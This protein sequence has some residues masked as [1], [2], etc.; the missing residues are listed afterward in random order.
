LA[1][2]IVIS[3]ISWQHFHVILGLKNGKGKR[4]TWAS[5]NSVDNLPRE[6]DL[7]RSSE[8]ETLS[9]RLRTFRSTRS[10]TMYPHPRVVNILDRDLDLALNER[11]QGFL[12]HTPAELSPICAQLE[13]RMRVIG[14]PLKDLFAVSLALREAVANAYRHGHRCD[15]RKNI[16]LRYAVTNDEV[17][18]EVEDQGPGFV[19]EQL[20]DRFVR[21]TRDRI[22][23]RGL[24]MMWAFTTWMSFNRLGNR[25]TL[26]K[27]RSPE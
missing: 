9:V 20:P 19:L 10:T 24:L 26:A 23:G 8:V 4:P 21:E 27:Q 15:P 12:L 7:K 1:G 18:L 3:V 16:Y 17:L 11:A 5:S 2:L 25:V 6:A 13:D 22:W 14:Y